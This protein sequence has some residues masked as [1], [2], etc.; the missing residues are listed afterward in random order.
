MLNQKVLS[1]KV[2]GQKV[3]SKKILVILLFSLFLFGCRTAP[4]LNI[5]DAPIETT[6]GKKPALSSVTRQITSAG[7]Q[8]GWQ[9]KKVKPGHIVAT[10]YLRDHM[11]QVNIF[12]SSRTYSITYKDSSDLKYDGTNIHSNYNGWIQRL[13]NSIRTNVYNGNP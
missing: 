2:L 9:M 10:L 4:I 1:R 8:L 13:D 3:F 12:Y 11:A 5:T 7:I 6:S